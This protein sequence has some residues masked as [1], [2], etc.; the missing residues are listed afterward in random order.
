MGGTSY[1]ISI[2]WF[3]FIELPHAKP[4][5]CHLIGRIQKL[6]R[7]KIIS[8]QNESMETKLTRLL[9]L[10]VVM[11]FLFA[12]STTHQA[13][14]VTKSGFLGNYSQLKE[15]DSGQALLRYVN[16]D[17][18]WSSYKKVILE[19]I[20]VYA[21]K[22]SNLA[23]ADKEEREVLASY[24]GAALRKVLQKDYVLVT[25]PGPDVMTIRAA[26]TDA[27]S[28]M[29]MLNTVTTILPIGLAASSLKR[30][31]T[32]S[33]SF[34]GEAQCEIEISDS[35]T[36]QRMAAAVD[37]RIGT[38]ALRS[39]F[40]GWSDAKEAFDYWAEQL[41]ERLAEARKGKLTVN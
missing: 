11:P 6:V 16:P 18:Q 28:S 14:S 10:A 35:R 33:D 27:D 29:V 25:T 5:V 41:G 34:V 9:S 2:I 12:C 19:P 39:K 3:K 20:R 40:G 21:G 17:V 8:S 1:S 30:V 38:K 22:N 7:T 26:I 32:G 23:S 4:G 37:K 15:G 13:R 31:V 36:D 24:F